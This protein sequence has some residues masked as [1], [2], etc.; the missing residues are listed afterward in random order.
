MPAGAMS[1]YPIALHLPPPGRP[2]WICPERER[3]D[4]LYLAWGYRYFGRHPVPVSRH[5]GWLYTLVL[6]GR[7]R[8]PL[9]NAALSLAPGDV[10]VEDAEERVGAGDAVLFGVHCHEK[11]PH[12]VEAT[13]VFRECARLDQADPTLTFA[14]RTVSGRRPE[15]DRS[16]IGRGWRG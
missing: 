4:L 11:P 15:P 12:G 14:A 7:P 9:E 13:F 16:R 10:G 1:R 5:D 8:L 3:L 2:R 6:R